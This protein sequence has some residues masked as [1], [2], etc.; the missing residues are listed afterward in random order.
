MDFLLLKFAFWTS[1][2]FLVECS[3]TK[4]LVF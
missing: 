2:E 4:V 1:L 3:V